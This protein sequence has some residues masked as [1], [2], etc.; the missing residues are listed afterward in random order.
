MKIILI[1]IIMSLSPLFFT[2]F[3]GLRAKA[4]LDKLMI[5]LTQLS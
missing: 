2:V 4:S 3:K 1:K 5:F